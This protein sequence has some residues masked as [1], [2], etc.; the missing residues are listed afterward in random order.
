MRRLSDL[1]TELTIYSS[2]YKICLEENNYKGLILTATAKVNDYQSNDKMKNVIAPI[3]AIL[4][5]KFMNMSRPA[6]NHKLLPRR[7]A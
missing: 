3:V 6:H 5:V 1:H 4:T 7:F 2:T